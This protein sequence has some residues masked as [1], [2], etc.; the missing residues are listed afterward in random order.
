MSLLSFG[1]LRIT[2]DSKKISQ[3]C[4]D[5][6]WSCPDSAIDV[7]KHYSTGPR[8]GTVAFVI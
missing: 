8:L 1:N 7:S 6:V 4:R 5:C 2:D 3:N